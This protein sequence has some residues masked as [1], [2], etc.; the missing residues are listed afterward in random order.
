MKS[1]EIF[2]VTGISTDVGKTI[3]SAI[4]ANALQANYWKPVQCGNLDASDSVLITNLIP[5]AKAIPSSYNFSCA[6][7]PHAA[8]KLENKTI[9]LAFIREQKLIGPT[10]IEGAGGALVPL[11][12]TED[13]IDIATAF[14]AE[15]I[16][17]VKYYLGCIN[18]TL[19]TISELKNRHLR[20]KGL[21]FNGIPN[22]ESK[23]IVLQ[24]SQLPCLLDIQQE[25]GF[26]IETIERYSLLLKERLNELP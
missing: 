19:L 7:S 25:D 17:V 11:N 21:V 12:E 14:K 26:S 13:V 1:S 22:E 2:F 23:K 15:V 6:Q 10:V 18:H 20:I 16:I 5:R 8:S 24:R 4:L 9:S 3:F